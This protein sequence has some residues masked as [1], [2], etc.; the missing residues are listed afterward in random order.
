MRSTVASPP[1]FVTAELRNRQSH[2]LTDD[3]RLADDA[4]DARHGDAADADGFADEGEEVLGGEDRL[5]VGEDVGARHAQQRDHRG[6]ID[7][8]GQRAHHRDDHE[9][10]E[11][12]TGGDDH[13]VFQADDVAQS[14]HG[15]RGVEREDHFEFVGGDAAPF[16]DARRDRLGPEA[17]RADYE[18][19]ETAHESR[20]GQ[21]FGLVAALLARDEDLGGRR[22]F[23]ERVFA[24]HL[25]DEVFAEGDQQHDAQQSAEQRREEHLPEGGVEPQ[26]VEGREGEDRSGDDHARR[27][28][29]RLDDDVLAQHVLL[30]QHRTHAYGDD[31]D[32]NGRFEDLPDLQAEEG[33]GGREDDGHNDAHRDR[34]GRHLFRVRRGRH[35]GCVLFA[36][37]EFAVG[38]FGQRGE[39]FILLHWMY[40]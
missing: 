11:A 7:G 26:N 21:Q 37:F 28:A 5:R 8:F 29:D 3:L 2:G 23:G 18:V 36:R 17:E 9:P 40:R 1:P 27:G 10:Y 34:I 35:D 32:G 33:R 6:G 38:V 30:A 39:L 22:G 19:I 14:Q 4:D 13:G 25:F 24:V 12:R 31:G 15:G 16:A 20:D